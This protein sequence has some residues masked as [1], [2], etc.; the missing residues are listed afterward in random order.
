MPKSP[1]LMGGDKGEGD[2]IFYHPHLTSPHQGG[3]HHVVTLQQAAGNYQVKK[4]QGHHGPAREVRGLWGGSIGHDSKKKLKF[5]LLIKHYISKR[6]RKALENNFT[7]CCSV[8]VSELEIN[9]IFSK[10]IDF[11]T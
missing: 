3:R 6:P 8:D 7:E 4:R 1:P 2:Q 11:R 10:K 9:S 5:S